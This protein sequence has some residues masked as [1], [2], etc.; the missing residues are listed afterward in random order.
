[1]HTKLK[2]PSPLSYLESGWID[3]VDGVKFR[4]DLLI[5]E[6]KKFIEK[7]LVTETYIKFNIVV[8]KKFHLVDDKVWAF[9]IDSMPETKRLVSAVSDLLDFNFITYRSVQPCTAYNWHYD[10]GQVCY[11]MP[12]ITNTG[13]WFVYEGR[14]F[15]MPADGSLYRVV[16]G[17]FHTFVNAGS[18][19]RVHITFERI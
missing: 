14:S 7:N 9:N 1:M 5:D 6:Y 18:D 12:L 13:A 16:N 19:P 8:Q 17:K 2:R 10:D 15:H 4:I 11:H 3:T